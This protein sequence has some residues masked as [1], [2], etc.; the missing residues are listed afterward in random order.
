MENAASGDPPSYTRAVFEQ[1]VVTT[2]AAINLPFSAVE[3]LEFCQMLRMLQ[4]NVQIP[5]RKQVKDVFEWRYSQIVVKSFQDLG[6]V[7]E[8][9]LALDCWTSPSYL[10]FMVIIAHYISENWRYCE[11]LIAFEHVPESYTGRNLAILVDCALQQYGCK[12]GVWIFV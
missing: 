1:Q 8:V 6:P 9:S 11:I 7:T 3:N 5:G 2:I 4:P 10:S 12:A